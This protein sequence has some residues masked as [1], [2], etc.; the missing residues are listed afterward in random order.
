[1]YGGFF[2]LNLEVVKEF[3]FD[4]RMRK[5]SERTVKG[6]KNNNLALF[7]FIEQEYSIT[8]LEESNYIAIKGYI[9]F[10]TKKG[11]SETYI[12]SLI[13]CYRAYFGYCIREGYIYKNPMDKVHLQKEPIPLINTF[14]ND[15]VKKLVKYYT[16]CKFLDIRNQ[17]I[18][19]MLLDTGMRNS[20]LCNLKM[21]D[22][23]STY[24]NILGKGKKVRHVPLTAIINKYLM[25]YI[26]V[27]GEY[28]KDKFNY[29]TEYLFLSQKGKRLTVETVERIVLDCGEAC[30][31]RDEIRIS[32]HTCRHYYAQTQLKN[33]CDL[34]TVAKLLGHSKID[35]TKRYLQ[36]MQEEETL[37]M[38]AKTSPL[39]NL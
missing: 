12:N 19:V 13:K 21:T 28:I 29:A 36:S 18:M 9:E 17:L 34:F 1:M 24:I 22:I 7:R 11:L 6:Y 31:I 25:K 3:L 39:M 30:D 37:L 10:L 38:G 8:E 32:P 14:T 27:R 5:L 2:M 23:R 4:C 20:E 33:G 15:E 26:R 35:V 16:G